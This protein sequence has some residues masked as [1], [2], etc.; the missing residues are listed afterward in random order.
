MQ[1]PDLPPN[2]ITARP[3][4]STSDFVVASSLDRVATP[5]S[6]SWQLY[7]NPIRESDLLPSHDET[8]VEPRWLSFL[9]KRLNSLRSLNAEDL[10]GTPPP[11]PSTLH[12]SFSFAIKYFPRDLPTPSIVPSSEGGVE[13]I[14]FKSG[15]HLEI[16]ITESGVY[17]WAHDLKKGTLW[18]GSLDEVLPNFLGLLNDLSR[19]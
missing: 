12:D 5:D 19:T 7:L 16:E 9:E 14:W 11:P 8:G 15:W 3:T 17:V 6:D 18:R 2:A 1:S 10:D 4:T 13:F